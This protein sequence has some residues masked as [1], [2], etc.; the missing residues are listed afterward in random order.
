MPFSM[1]AADQ[2]EEVN[3]D[4]TMPI[5]QNGLVQSKEGAWSAMENLLIPGNF[6]NIVWLNWYQ[7]L[8]VI[9]QPLKVV[10]ISGLKKW[11]GYFRAC[12][13]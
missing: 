12:L 10:F 7:K 2:A 3:D 9:L 8:Y 13:T 5:T 11:L 4:L 1:P 6:R